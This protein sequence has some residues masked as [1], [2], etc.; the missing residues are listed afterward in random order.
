MSI[1]LF[2][3]GKGSHF[4]EMKL[5]GPRAAWPSTFRFSGLKAVGVSESN[6]KTSGRHN[7]SRSAVLSC[8]MQLTIA[9]LTS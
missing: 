6:F 7:D 4:P 9:S 1:L 5:A 2:G 3:D 8:Q